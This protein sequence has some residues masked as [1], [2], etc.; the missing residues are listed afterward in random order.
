[1]DKVYNLQVIQVVLY[2][3]PSGLSIN[4]LTTAAE[5]V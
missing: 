2:L 1:M 4:T 5:Y 3:M